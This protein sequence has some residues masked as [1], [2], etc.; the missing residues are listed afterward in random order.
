[1]IKVYTT[2]GNI[3]TKKIISKSDQTL[4]PN[5]NLQETWETD[6]H[7]KRHYGV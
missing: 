2:S 1:M 7:I 6:G 3:V 4:N 5:T